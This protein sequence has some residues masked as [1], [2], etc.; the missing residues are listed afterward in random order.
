M[1]DVDHILHRSG[2]QW[3]RPKTHE[4]K[5]RQGVKGVAEMVEH[6]VASAVDDA[7]LEYGVI[8][9][10]GADD[11]LRRPFRLVIGRVTVGPCA[12]EAQKEDFLHACRLRSRDDVA[13]S[14]DVNALIGLEAN[15]A[16]DTGAVGD[17][18]ATRKR[19]TQRFNAVQPDLSN[20]HAG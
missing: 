10:R 3:L 18:S 13:R 9:T 20:G 19:L 5:H 4:A 7:R 8:E 14:L 16:V 17:G 6:V 12:Q 11:F 2:P 1:D 15:L